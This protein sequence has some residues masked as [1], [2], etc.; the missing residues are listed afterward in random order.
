LIGK[1]IREGAFDDLEKKGKF[2]DLRIDSQTPPEWQL[3]YQLLKDAN[4]RP[5]WI[6]L[7]L[8]IRSAISAAREA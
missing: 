8:E 1:A 6:E 2:L 7:D 4:F 5:L 3:A